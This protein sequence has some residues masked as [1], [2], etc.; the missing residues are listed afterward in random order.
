MIVM[1]EYPLKMMDHLYF[2]IFCNSLQPLFKVLS[3]NIIKKDIIAM[4][5]N[6]EEK[7]PKG[8]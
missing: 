2:K 5:E 3:R 7:N 6:W 1:H 8:D 4:Y